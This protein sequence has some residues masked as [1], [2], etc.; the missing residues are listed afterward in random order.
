LIALDGAFCQPEQVTKITLAPAQR[1]D[2]ILDMDRGS[3]EIAE[4]STGETY[5]AATLLVDPALG[6]SSLNKTP[7]NTPKPA[8][9][10]SLKQTPPHPNSHAGRRDGQFTNSDV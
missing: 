5:P 10:P 4:I 9:L 3:I 6:S 1:A 2:V 8:A 7:I